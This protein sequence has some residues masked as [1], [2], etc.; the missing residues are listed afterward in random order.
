MSQKV[1]KKPIHLFSE[2]FGWYGAIAILGA[3]ALVSFSFI[4]ADG[5][6]FQLLNLTGALGLL[7]IGYYKKVYQSVVLNII[8]S[9]IGILAIANIIF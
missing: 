2:I 7:A 1:V 9:I 3:Y 4:T 8:W 6:I 5:L